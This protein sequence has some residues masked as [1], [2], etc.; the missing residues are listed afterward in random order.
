[1]VVYKVLS[2]YRFLPGFHEIAVFEKVIDFFILFLDGRYREGVRALAR[3]QISSL[4]Y[5]FF[6]SSQHVYIG[7]GTIHRSARS[8][9]F[10]KEQNLILDTDQENKIMI[11]QEG[12]GACQRQNILS[13]SSFYQFH[14]EHPK[15]T[16]F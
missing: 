16:K 3:A 13:R 11:C 12:S 9:N 8:L 5:N 4:Y 10:G 15:N 14:K 2:I 6:S 1:M 7:A